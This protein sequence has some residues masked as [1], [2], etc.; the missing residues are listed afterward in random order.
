MG[1]M[2][3]DFLIYLMAIVLLAVVV[4]GIGAIGGMIGKDILAE[5]WCISLGHDTGSWVDDALRCIT[6]TMG[7]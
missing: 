7:E 1:S 4:L 3:E 5:Q 2:E 6:Y